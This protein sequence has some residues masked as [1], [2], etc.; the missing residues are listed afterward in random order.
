MLVGLDL[1]IALAL[2]EVCPASDIEDASNA[3]LACFSSRGKALVLL[4]A[5]IQKEV[6][7][8]GKK[9]STLN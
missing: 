8:T 5:V 4:K 2:C 3:L 6:Q 7:N 9:K 1:N